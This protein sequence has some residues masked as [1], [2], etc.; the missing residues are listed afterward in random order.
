M[1]ELFFK[2]NCACF[3][4]ISKESVCQG[5]KSGK[6]GKILI[7]VMKVKVQRAVLKFKKT[8]VYLIL[9]AQWSLGMASIQL[10][11]SLH[12]LEDNVMSLSRYWHIP[13]FMPAMPELQSFSQA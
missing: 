1:E 12:S 9:R 2:A 6:K 7:W 10:T 3:L 11:C 4:L 5:F 13:I 8:P